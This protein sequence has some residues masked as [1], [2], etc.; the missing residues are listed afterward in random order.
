MV[1]SIDQNWMVKSIGSTYW[2]GWSTDLSEALELARQHIS[3][4]ILLHLPNKA[5]FLQ[6]YARMWHIRESHGGTFKTVLRA[7]VA[8]IRQSRPN[9]GLGFEVKVLETFHVVLSSELA[10]KHIP[11]LLV[12]Q[13]VLVHADGVAGKIRAMLPRMRRANYCLSILV[14][15]MLHDSG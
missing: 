5:I 4:L 1:K 9:Y 3:H 10:R 6:S 14:Y 13:D 8:H 12:H 2:R 15:L 11:H 7:N